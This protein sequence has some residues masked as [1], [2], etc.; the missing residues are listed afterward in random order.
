VYTVCLQ[1]SVTQF[2]SLCWYKCFLL[3][4]L[5]GVSVGHRVLYNICPWII[6]GSHSQCWEY[7]KH[8]YFT[9]TDRHFLTAPG[10]EAC[11]QIPAL[12]LSVSHCISVLQY[13]HTDIRRE[14]LLS[15][16]AVHV[17]LGDLFP[18][19]TVQCILEP[20]YFWCICCVV[21][22]GILTANFWCVLQAA[23]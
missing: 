9:H 8:V 22:S 14:L 23:I 7:N 3:Y 19:S 6:F 5:S 12:W 2:L 1:Y 11:S 18:C 16:Y 20:R 15:V 10:K 17:V 13:S 4:N 21:D